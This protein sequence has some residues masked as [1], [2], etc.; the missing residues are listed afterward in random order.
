MKDKEVPIY[1]VNNSE[2]IIFRDR[3]TE[4][5]LPKVLFEEDTKL[6]NIAPMRHDLRSGVNLG[7]K[8]LVDLVDPVDVHNNDMTK[9]ITSVT[10]ALDPD[11]TILDGVGR[12]F[13]VIPSYA[14]ITMATFY[15]HQM[16]RYALM[17]GSK[18]LFYPSGKV[19]HIIENVR[20]SANKNMES[21]IKERLD[22]LSG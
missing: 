15:W 7:M 2:K 19:K 8:S 5:S 17:P 3:D 10:A 22:D 16:I 14:M 12:V 21:R 18:I 11:L 6:I 20:K 1:N 13:L 4:F 9:L